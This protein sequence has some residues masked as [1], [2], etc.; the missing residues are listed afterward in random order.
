MHIPEVLLTIVVLVLS[1]GGTVAGA[2]ITAPGDPVAG[3]PDN[4]NWPVNESPLCAIDNNV[5]TKYL[6]KNGVPCGLIIS[7]Q[8]AI[9]AS[10]GTVVGGLAFTTANDVPARDPHSYEV[11]GS[12][13]LTVSETGHWTLVASG[14][15]VDFAGGTWPRKTRNTTPIRFSN[16]AS[17]LHYK[18]VFPTNGGDSYVQIA[19]IELLEDVYDCQRIKEDDML[20]SS[21]LNEDCRIDLNDFI[22]LAANWLRCND[23]ADPACENPLGALPSWAIGP[24]SRPAEAQPVIRPNPDSSFYCPM[25]Q[26]TINWEKLHTFNPAAVVNEDKIYVMYRAE[27]DTGV[28]QVGGH[29]SRGGLA[30]SENGIDFSFRSSPVLYPANDGQAAYEWTGGC[31]DP[32]LAQR[33]DGLFIVTYTQ[34]T[35]IEMDRK[36][37]LGIASSTDLVNWTKYGSAFAGT[38]FENIRMKSAA[39]VHQGVDGRLRA[40]KINGKYWM[41]FGESAVHIAWSDDLIHWTPLDNGAGQLLKIMEVRPG[42][43]DSLLTEVGP[44]AVL[45]N[46]GIILIYNGKNGNPATNGDPEL[47]QGVYACGQALFDKNDP[48]RPLKRLNKPFFKPELDWEKSGQYAAGTTFAEGLVL[49]KGN[50]YL[51]YGCADSF[52]G[53]AVAAQDELK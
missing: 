24:F 27:D 44:Q 26:R 49:F 53:V 10:A 30:V 11:F 13:D 8:K 17:Y 42:Y 45:T 37:R 28:M 34:Y 7:P 38:P 41:Y 21:D 51:Y 32:R 33:E 35:G 36:V 52:V 4:G 23:P 5:S 25:R 15:I 29:T 14:A 19:E 47:P 46:D 6:H 2:D 43:F 31:E 39:V 48:S 20:M 3:L 18:V 1:I 22:L 40:V 50:W 9:A 12:N 16:S